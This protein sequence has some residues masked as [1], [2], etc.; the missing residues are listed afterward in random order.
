[1]LRYSIAKLAAG[2]QA[3]GTTTLLQPVPLRRAAELE[4][5][6]ALKTVLKG[7]AAEVRESVIPVYAF[8]L[9]QQRAEKRLTG[10]GASRSW[11][12]R[13]GSVII[14][15][16]RR[17]TDMVE[18]VLRLEAKRYDEGFMAEAKR[19][20]G[21]DL[22]AVIR[23]EDLEDAIETAMSRNVSLITSMSA[24]MVK[25]VEQVVIENSL[26]GNSVKTLK[27]KL[28]EQFGIGSR[29]A[30]L[31]AR[32]QMSKFH[33]DLDQLRQSQAGISEYDWATSHDERVRGNPKGRYPKA[34]PSH[35]DLDG[36]RFTWAKG[37]SATGG[38][39]PGQ[40]ILCRCRARAV[41]VF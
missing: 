30:E 25:R 10:D 41:I 37:P 26:A 23:T 33:A 7:I 13:L 24:D 1:M 14:L 31:I 29:K 22:R 27:S 5:E 6:K 34:R 11:F 8:D 21:I 28:V 35:Y 2:K 40:P 3:K 16:N 36:Q 38:Q 4:L 32:D 17:A 20:L 12:Q 15:L 39:H 18:R 19:V 9:Q